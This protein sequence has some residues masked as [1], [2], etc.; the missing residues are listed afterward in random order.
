MKINS[1]NAF[2]EVH[3]LIIETDINKL[4]P[5]TKRYM[6]LRGEIDSSLIDNNLISEMRLQAQAQGMSFVW[7]YD[8]P[9]RWPRFLIDFQHKKSRIIIPPFLFV[10]TLD[11]VSLMTTN[12]LYINLR[13][14]NKQLWTDKYK[15]DID[16]NRNPHYH[17]RALLLLADAY[18]TTH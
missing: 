3:K 14:D 15:I 13:A 9:P 16:E 7:A 8:E 10:S 5:S 4:P 1:L 6:A 12:G 17:G 2:D 18:G 11:I